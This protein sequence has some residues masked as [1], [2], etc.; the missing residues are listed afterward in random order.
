[1]KNL[2]FTL[3]S[4][5]A[6]VPAALSQCFPDTMN[7]SPIT[8]IGT[9]QVQFTS[10]PSQA[11]G[12]RIDKLGLSTFDWWYFDAVSTDGSQ[13]F[14]VIF[15]TSSAIGFSFDFFSAVDP[16][17]VW[18]FATF[19]DGSP[20]SVFPVPAVSV[21][22]TTNGDGASGDWHGSGI[23]F[24]G[25]SDLSSYVVKLDNPVIGLTGTFTLKSR[26]PGHY[27]CGPLGPNQDEQSLPHIGW[28][29]VMPGADAVVDVKVLGKPLKFEGH[30]YH[31]KNWGDIP[32]ITALK[33]WYWGHASVG[34]YDLVFFDMIDPQGVN[35]VGGYALKDGAVVAQ[36]CTT[37]VKIRPI[38]TPYP[39]T[40]FTAVPK[41]LTLNMTLNDGTHLDAVLTQVTTQLNIGIYV[42]WIGTIEATIGGLTSTG[43]A[44]WEQFAVS[45][46]P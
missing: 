20:A 35:K 7:F 37:G 11:D 10:C 38:D 19:G 5:A 17:N 31:D 16:L 2:F 8:S 40:I 39:P 15:F 34:G 44:L 23:S 32:F 24:K 12:P 46:T 13:A 6:L 22:T 43:S 29:N 9:P 21:T 25:E 18:V 3:A 41:S 30:G 14:T 33:S 26:G 45:P 1:M 28:V 27:N 36:T 4:F 42:R